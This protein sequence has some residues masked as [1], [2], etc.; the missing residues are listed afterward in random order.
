MQHRKNIIDIE[1]LRPNLSTVAADKRSPGNSRTKSKPDVNKLPSRSVKIN[2][3]K[4]IKL[5]LDKQR[6]IPAKVVMKTSL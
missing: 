5:S 4:N 6:T 2:F 3:Y 1:N